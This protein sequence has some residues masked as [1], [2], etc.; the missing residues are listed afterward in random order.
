MYFE[1]A[2]ERINNINWSGLSVRGGDDDKNLAGKYLHRMAVFIRDHSIDRKIYLTNIAAELG[3]EGSI[4]IADY[5][6]IEAQEV[7]KRETL[8]RYMT[9]FYLQLAKYADQNP[10]AY[11]Y[12][13]VYDPMIQLLEEGFIYG[14]RERGIMIYGG[15]FYPLSN[16]YE[17]FLNINPE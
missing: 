10:D 3:D 9:M 7:L 14:H 2:I 8:P 17:K 6:R 4:D 13:Q 5:C 16:W 11:E 15:T 1:Q 12:M